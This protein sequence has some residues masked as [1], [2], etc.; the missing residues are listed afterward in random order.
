MSDLLNDQ[1]KLTE[2]DYW[3]RVM[4]RPQGWHYDMDIIWLLNKL[5][6][7]G[8]KKGDTI[9]DAG[10]GMGITQ[11]ILAARG[12]NVISLD[13]S[14]RN[15]PSLAQGIFEIEIDE[16][17]KLEYK[18]DYIGFIKYGQDQPGSNNHHK[19]PFP[20]KVWNAVQKG[21]SYFFS[22]LRIYLRKQKNLKYNQ[23]EKKKN[24]NGF[25]TIRFI[26]AAFHEIPLE[27]ETVD[28]LISVSA[29]EHSDI[30]LLKNN[31]SEMKRVVKLGHPLLITSSA[32]DK[33]E[34]WFHD[35][36]QGWCFSNNT[37][38]QLGGPDIKIKFN[39]D[40]AEKNILSSTL[41]RNRIDS[42]YVNDPESGFYKR[43]A[44]LLPYLPVGIKIIHD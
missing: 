13:F 20:I 40:I 2:I 9:L 34:D 42:Y 6:E 31:I 36:T 37:L 28:A 44:D 15:Y 18:H 3:L 33:S 38:H 8:V 41:W 27:N 23:L 7:L 22:Q 35:K 16:Q 32:T 5:E 26:R 12:Y 1:D 10:A 39:H 17:D 4:N 19:F 30:K 24:H 21:P 25:G 29:I 11:F 43:Q 14:P